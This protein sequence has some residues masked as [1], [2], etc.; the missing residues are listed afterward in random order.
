MQRLE[1]KVAVVTGGGRGIG[2]GTARV[3][4]A[5]GAAVL[6]SSRTLGH[7][8]ETVESIV[9][10]G[11]RAEAVGCDV[12]YRDQVDA[13][14]AA[15][16]DAFGPPDILVNNAQGTGKAR[17]TPPRIGGGNAVLAEATDEDFLAAFEGGVLSS[18]YGMQAV[19]PYMRE[20]GGSIVNMASSTGIM[21]DPGFAPYGTAKE[22]IRGLTKHAAREWGEFGIRVN[23][24]APAALGE[25]AAAFRDSAPKRWEAIIK[26]IPLRYMGDPEEDIGRG[27]LALV[28]DLG[29][30]TGATIALDGGRCILR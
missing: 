20:R 16:V 8:E 5:E 30:L 22:G 18:L 12:C 1:G 13:M 3:L 17:E 27:I 24:V 9:A 6:V 15:A 11:G 14:V 25:G 21:G 10:D 4:A 29:Y 28:T 19:F 2:R 26:Q 23:V 7:A